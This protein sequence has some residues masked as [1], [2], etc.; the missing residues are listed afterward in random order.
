MNE[1]Y[2]ITVLGNLNDLGIAATII[3]LVCIFASLNFQNDWDNWKN[4]S[5]VLVSYLY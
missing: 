3:G 2:W 5:K 4:Y 1:L